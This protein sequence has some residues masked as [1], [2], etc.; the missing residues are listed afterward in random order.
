MRA[1]WIGQREVERIG[2]G[3]PV[4][5]N[6]V[7]IIESPGPV[8]EPQPNHFGLARRKFQTVPGRHLG[9]GLSRVHGVLT[10]VN[11][12]F[13]DAILDVRAGA[14]SLENPLVIRLVLREK[15]LLCALAIEIANS[16]IALLAADDVFGFPG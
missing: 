1:A 11:D 15:Q 3:D 10:A 6:L 7:E 2:F 9:P 5:K 14:S 16:Q 13:V 8:G 12:V 4:G